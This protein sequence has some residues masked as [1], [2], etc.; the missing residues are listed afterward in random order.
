MHV[1][2]RKDVHVQFNKWAK[3]YG[4]IFSLIVGTQ[5]FVVL[6]SDVVVK[7][8][9]DKRGAIYSDRMDA[10]LAKLCSEDHHMLTMG[11]GPQWRMARRLLNSLLN[12]N[13]A[14]SYVR[15]QLL[16]NKQLMYELLEEPNNFLASLQR[17]ANSLA[18]SMVYGRRT[19][20]L[21]DPLMKEIL[22]GLEEF[23]EIAS[24]FQAALL[25]CYPAR[26]LYRRVSSNYVKL[27]NGVKSDMKV[28]KARPCLCV[29][30]SKVQ[31]KEGF[32]DT[33]A[34]YLAGNLIE[35]G[36]E[37]TSSTLYAFIQ[38]MVI[39]PEVMKKAQEE[40]DRVIGPDRL[41]TMNDEQ[42]LQYIRACVKESLRWMPTAIT[43]AIPH[44]VIQDDEYQGYKIPRGA[45]V[46]H[47]VYSINM[48]PARYPDPRRFEPDRYKDDFQNAA[49]A[50]TASDVSKRD[51]FTFGAGRRLC[52]GIHVAERSLF[53]GIARLAWAFDVNPA[54]D[55]DGK[56]IIPDTDSYTSG[57]VVMPT[58]FKARLTPRSEKRAEIVR[59]EWKQAEE[60]L[61][62]PVTKQWKA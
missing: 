20:Q 33:T 8:L 52:Q 9:L 19:P 25:D 16:E 11:Y 24:S 54:T 30:M 5:T 61:L 44:C 12:V 49:D 50:A 15:Y 28:G 56:P 59:V 47:N 27:Y 36:T 4:P 29:D 34:G 38:A 57:F 3:E 58:P 35:A 10:Y 13:V 39:F 1:L 41:P 62:D 21:E 7:E 53:L 22:H 48:D 51:H 2:P 37:T 40:V 43:G 46:I 18:T 45:A 32:S 42:D 26:R 17:Y 6:S 55:S 60:E 31:E 14:K 23:G